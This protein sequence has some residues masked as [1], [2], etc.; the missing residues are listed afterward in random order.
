MSTTI[1]QQTLAEA[2]ADASNYNAIITDQAQEANLVAVVAN[3]ARYVALI[4]P[5][6]RQSEF[7]A[8]DEATRLKFAQVAQATLQREGKDGDYLTIF[9]EE[10]I[11]IFT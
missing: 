4:I 5:V 3:M 6:A 11:N 2:T 8:A 9:E 1:I 7:A 10:Y